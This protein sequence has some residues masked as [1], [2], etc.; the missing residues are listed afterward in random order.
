MIA[1]LRLPQY[2]IR[3]LNFNYMLFKQFYLSTSA[4]ARG[5]KAIKSLAVERFLEDIDEKNI[6]GWIV[7]CIFIRNHLTENHHF[8]V[9]FHK[10][11]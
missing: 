8:Y 10:F 6:G 4:Y 9:L 3:Q 11:R 5:W 1:S 2:F 7:E